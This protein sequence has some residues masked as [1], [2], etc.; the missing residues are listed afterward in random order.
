MLIVGTDYLENNSSFNTMMKRE[1]ARIFVKAYATS[2]VVANTPMAVQWMGSGYNA[3]ALAASI[4]AYVGVPENG[5]AIASGCMGWMQIRGDVDDV[6]GAT[7]S[8]TGSV[9][10]NV[11]WAGATGLGA[12]TSA[13]VGNPALSVGVLTE[14]TSSST[15]GNIYLCGYYATPI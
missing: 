13:N 11:Y 5:E 4:Y 12:T 6:Q 14:E 7:A 1:G 15:T 3:T 10:H 8:F 2:G 9:G